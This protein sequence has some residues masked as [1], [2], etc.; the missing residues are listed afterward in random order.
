MCAFLVGLVVY[1]VFYW[2]SSEKMIA[3]S[4][5]LFQVFVHPRV[6]EGVTDAVMRTAGRA[7]CDRVRACTGA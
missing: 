3:L 4:V 6:E 2:L 5:L 7:Y 1:F